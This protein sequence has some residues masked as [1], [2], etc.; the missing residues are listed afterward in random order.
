MKQITLVFVIKE[1]DEEQL[2]LE[3]RNSQLLNDWLC[4]EWSV[5]DATDRQKAWYEKEVEDEA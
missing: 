5:Q 3:I 4:Y 1:E 2:D